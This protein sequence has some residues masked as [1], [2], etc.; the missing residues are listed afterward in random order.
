MSLS[1]FCIR[2]GERIQDIDYEYES[3][4]PLNRIFDL[5]LSPFGIQQAYNVGIILSKDINLTL[6]KYIYVS[7]MLRC[8]QTA[9]EIC[10]ILKIKMIIVPSLSYG[11]HIVKENGLKWIENDRL[12]LN[13]NYIDN[14]ESIFL[15]KDEIL[16]KFKCKEVEIEFV[17]IIH[18]SLNECFDY[19]FAENKG[20]KEIILSVT[21]REKDLK[22][23]IN[24]KE[25]KV[26]KNVF[27]IVDLKRKK[28][29][30]KH[31][32]IFKYKY[33][34]NVIWYNGKLEDY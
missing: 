16:Q 21:H 1:L 9:F 26:K 28:D 34:D 10:K 8:I 31:C 17:D 12:A 15:S 4:C 14:V 25:F 19:L 32:E 30:P 3:K 23:K 2:H 20:N 13:K 6:T 27:G 18:G 33:I 11:A 7:P 5:P 22:F 29:K 24:Q